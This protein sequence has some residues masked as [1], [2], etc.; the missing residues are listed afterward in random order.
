MD[1]IASIDVW[2]N[3]IVSIDLHVRHVDMVDLFICPI[4]AIGLVD[5]V[6]NDT[7]HL[8][9]VSNGRQY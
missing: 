6:V 3:S 2:K 1:L 5:S 4:A 9:H 7:F 8:I